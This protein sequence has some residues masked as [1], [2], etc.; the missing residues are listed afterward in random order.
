MSNFD[1]IA[2]HPLKPPVRVR[3]TI[4]GEEVE[5]TE[6]QLEQLADNEAQTAVLQSSD[7]YMDVFVEGARLLAVKQ[8]SHYVI[9][10]ML[11]VARTKLPWF[12]E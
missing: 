1:V 6:S 10:K 3:L 9:A 4:Y 2:F 12:V 11:D 7:Y 5:L 8:G